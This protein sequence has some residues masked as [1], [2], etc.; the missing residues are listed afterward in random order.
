MSSAFGG[1]R[2]SLRTWGDGFDAPATPPEDQHPRIEPVAERGGERGVCEPGGDQGACRVG[3]SDHAAHA[4]RLRR[5][6]KGRA[7]SQPVGDAIEAEDEDGGGEREERR[8]ADIEHVSDAGGGG[9]A[10][11]GGLAGEGGEG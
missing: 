7:S 11:A 1:Y 3:P 9:L 6:P 4:E 2:E 8:E 10:G 5:Q